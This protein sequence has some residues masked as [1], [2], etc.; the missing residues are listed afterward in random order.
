MS[1]EIEAVTEGAKPVQESAKMGR[2]LVEAGSDLARFLGKALGTVP[3]DTVGLLGGDYLHDLR[4]RNLDRISRK[5]EEVLRDRGVEDPEPIG[6]KAL[7]PAQEAASEE[8]DGKLQGMWANLLANAMDP[9]SDTALLRVFTETLKQFEPIDALVFQVMGGISI[10][11]ET[12]EPVHVATGQ[13][14]FQAKDFDL[15]ETK[16]ELSVDR[17]QKLNCIKSSKFSVGD[18][19][20]AGFELSALGIELYLACADDAPD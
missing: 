11:A 5:T 20:N 18:L 13:T 12:L 14:L 17:L 8:T 10:S 1:D 3:E 2:A 9:N 19:I 15:R 4:I 6:P 16:L 7:L